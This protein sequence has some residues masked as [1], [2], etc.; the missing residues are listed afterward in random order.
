MGNLRDRKVDLLST[1]TLDFHGRQIK[2]A[3][4]A[5]DPLDYVTFQQLTKAVKSLLDQ[6]A[7]LGD[8]GTGGGG[9]ATT[10]G[11]YVVPIIGGGALP[12]PSKGY[13]QNLVA[14][15]N[16]VLTNLSD[17]TQTSWILRFVQDSTGGRTLTFGTNYIGVTDLAL[18]TDPST[19]SMLHFTTRP[20]G[21]CEM[22]FVST[23]LAI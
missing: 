4:D 3:A 20:D 13:T 5:V 16:I 12:A 17:N 19:R 22:N 14:T 8:G 10:T 2:N 1:D 21:K 23:G 18:L 15:G 9:N 7:A 6:I 11:W